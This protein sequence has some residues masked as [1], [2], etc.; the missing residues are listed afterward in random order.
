MSAF[1]IPLSKSSSDFSKISDRFLSG[2]SNPIEQQVQEFE[3]QISETFGGI[4][5]LCVSSGTAGLHLALLALG[6]GPTDHVICSAFTFI[7]SANPILYQGGIPVF[8]DCEK[9]TWNIDPNKLRNTMLSLEQEGIKPKAIIVPHIYGMPADLQKLVVIASEFNVPII[10]DAA[11]ALGSKLN[12]CMVGTFGSV[13]VVSFNRNKVLSLNGG[14][15]IISSDPELIEKARYYSTQAKSRRNYYYHKH[16]GYNYRMNPMIAT[17][18]SCIWPM[19][20]QNVKRRRKIFTRYQRNLSNIL[21]IGFQMQPTNYYSNRWLS[22]ITIDSNITGFSSTEAQRSLKEKGIESK[23][24]WK[25]LGQQPVFDDFCGFDDENSSQLFR[26][27]LCLPSGSDLQDGEID[28]VCQEIVKL[29][30]ST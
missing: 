7:A 6:I 28:Y 23:R 14:G 25:P 29:A 22:C 24:G 9:D 18:G 26:N 11:Q 15:A 27:V 2:C 30:R 4:H 10:E 3:S 5:C 17:Y 16:A 21:G 1:K 13:A 8:V 19:W 12:G 20:K